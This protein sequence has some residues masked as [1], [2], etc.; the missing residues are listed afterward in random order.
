MCMCI[1]VYVWACV[2][3]YLK[4]R[5]VNEV[6]V[7][8][9]LI[10]GKSVKIW[11]RA[12]IIISLCSWKKLCNLPL[13]SYHNNNAHIIRGQGF[14]RHLDW[15]YHVILGNDPF[16]QI[17]EHIDCKDGMKKLNYIVCALSSVWLQD[18]VFYRC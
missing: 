13:S 16:I 9:Y 15:N 17:L 2:P 6:G 3:M 12:V 4:Y 18:F 11:F 14:S 5:V 10:A 7:F 1:F 8:S